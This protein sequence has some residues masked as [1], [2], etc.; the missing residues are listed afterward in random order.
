MFKVKN[1]DNNPFM[2]SKRRFLLIL[3]FEDK[4]IHYSKVNIK[5]SYNRHWSKVSCGG[6][7]LE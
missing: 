2:I 4:G 3:Y 5:I 6:I 7:T 1:S